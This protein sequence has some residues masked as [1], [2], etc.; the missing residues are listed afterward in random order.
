MLRTAPILPAVLDCVAVLCAGRTQVL[1][2]T[3]AVELYEAEFVSVPEIVVPARKFPIVI[4][5]PEL[6]DQDCD[7]LT[8]IALPVN[9]IAVGVD[10]EVIPVKVWYAAFPVIVVIAVALAAITFSAVSLL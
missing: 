10:V 9:P 4:F 8:M 6:L 2:G 1:P 3:L 7:S 5:V